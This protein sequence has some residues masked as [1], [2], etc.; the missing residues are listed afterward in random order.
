MR[1]S[2]EEVLLPTNLF[3]NHISGLSNE[4]FEKLKFFKPTTLSQAARISGI[5]PAAI[6]LLAVE[7]AKQS[8]I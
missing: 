6:S 5:T 1:K 3:D 2:G 4:V 8:C 7:L